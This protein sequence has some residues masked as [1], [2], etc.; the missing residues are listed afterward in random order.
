MDGL[1]WFVL[2]PGVWGIFFAS[3]YR[4][5]AI[6]LLSTEE[7]LKI[8]GGRAGGLAPREATL[9]PNKIAAS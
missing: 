5:C 7:D 9:T 6:D 8:L 4:T 2:S 1:V 3:H